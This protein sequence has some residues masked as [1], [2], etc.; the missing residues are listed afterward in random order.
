MEPEYQYVNQY[1]TGVF[2]FFLAQKQTNFEII[3]KKNI[4]YKIHFVLS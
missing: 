4:S 1:I 2:F 3:I